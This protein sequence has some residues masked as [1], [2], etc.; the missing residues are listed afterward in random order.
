MTSH[1]ITSRNFI[2]VSLTMA[3]HQR[4]GTYEGSLYGAPRYEPDGI[5]YDFEV[6]DNLVVASPG[7]VSTVHHHW[8]KGFYGRGNTSS[9]IYGGQGQRYISGNYGSLYQSGQSAAQD[10]GMYPEGKDYRYWL[11]GQPQQYSQTEGIESVWSPN[12]KMY[13]PQSMTPADAGTYQ[14]MPDGLTMLDDVGGDPP[15]PQTRAIERY[16]RVSADTSPE[17]TPIP[18]TDIGYELIDADSSD[19]SDPSC[20]CNVSVAVPT[21]SPWALFFLF[22]MAFVAFDFW[23]SAGHMFIRQQLHGG[24]S[25]TWQRAV[26]YAVIVT[27]AF[28]M[29]AWIGGVP[30]STFEAV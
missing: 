28:A 13:T 24:K 2:V 1:I 27:I 30:V 7:G 3:K 21:L 8:T 18:E 17:P 25:I 22:L 15:Q 19:P 16:T 9:D 5:G 14:D 26:M 29:L 23:A 6:P 4:L 20:D 12:M 10:M 11:N